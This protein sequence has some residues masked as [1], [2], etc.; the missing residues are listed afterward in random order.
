MKRTIQ[1][2]G[3]R[4]GIKCEGSQADRVITVGTL[5]VAVGWN[6]TES[7]IIEWRQVE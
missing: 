4:E 7:K 3:N 2:D 6:G 1:L 5:D